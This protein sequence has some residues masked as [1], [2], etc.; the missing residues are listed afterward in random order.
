MANIL[1]G[2]RAVWRKLLCG[3]DL[4]SPDSLFVPQAETYHRA[5]ENR[6]RVLR[7]TTQ[8]PDKPFDDLRSAP[9]HLYRLGLVLDALDLGV[10][11]EVLDFGA[12]TCWVSR[13]L[14]RMGLKT[15]SLDISQSAVDLGADGFRADPR[16]NWDLDPEFLTYRGKELPFE[17]GRFETVVSYDAF[18]HVPNQIEILEELGR[19]TKA[20]GRVV[21][22]EPLLGHSSTTHA[23]L[24]TA[25]HGVLER[26]ISLAE[27]RKASRDAGFTRLVVKPYSQDASD[28]L[29]TPSVFRNAAF[30]AEQVAKRYLDRYSVFYL[31]QR[32]TRPFDSTRPRGLAAEID[33]RVTGSTTNARTFEGAPGEP[34]PLQITVSNI[35]QAV[36]LTDPDRRGGFVRIGVQQLDSAGHLINRE[37][38]RV[39]LGLPVEPLGSR[40]IRCD[41]PAPS[42][43][44]EYVLRFDMV[45]ENVA[46]MAELG[47]RTAELACTVRACEEK[48]FNK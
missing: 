32:G 46:W 19:V 38:E 14:N 9:L 26:D 17:D 25:T 28:E 4:P 20:G 41:I 43:P 24:E 44:G 12:G 36:W 30:G 2:A 18:H 15:V 37:Y 27:L 13:L 8:P 34:I 31:E 3:D 23:Q 21:F 10:R 42:A 35:G 1:R 48:T 40:T 11:D 39:D 7:A 47:S 16:V 22:C 29:D 5:E 6:Y 45:A 33:V